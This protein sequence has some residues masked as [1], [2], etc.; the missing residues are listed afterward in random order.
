VLAGYLSDRFGHAVAF[1]ALSAA[2][3]A[4]LILVLAFMPETRRLAASNV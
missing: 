4:G 1:S 3:F 2:A